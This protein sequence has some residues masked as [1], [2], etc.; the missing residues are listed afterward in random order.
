MKHSFLGCHQVHARRSDAVKGREGIGGIQ[1]NGGFVHSI[2][3]RSSCILDDS[4]P[5]FPGQF[6]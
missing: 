1:L 2:A 4:I 5:A 3:K 6:D